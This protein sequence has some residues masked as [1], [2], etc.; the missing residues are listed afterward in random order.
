MSSHKSRIGDPDKGGSQD[1]DQL[2]LEAFTAA[3]DDS[4]R[5]AVRHVPAASALDPDLWARIYAEARP[6]RQRGRSH[7]RAARSRLRASGLVRAVS[8]SER[9]PGASSIP[10][11]QWRRGITAFTLVALIGCVVFFLPDE[12]R[13]PQFGAV[14]RDAPV[15]TT[16]AVVEVV[17]CPVEPLTSDEVLSIVVNMEQWSG[18]SGSYS[19][20]ASPP[21]YDG[22]YPHTETWLPDSNGYVRVTDSN[23]HDTQVRQPNMMEFRDLE[24][25]VNLYMNCQEEGTNFQIWALESQV[26]VQRQILDPLLQKIVPEGTTK[27]AYLPEITETM[28]IDEIERLGPLPRSEST[29]AQGSTYMSFGYLGYEIE[30]NPRIHNAYI[31]DE[32]DG[33]RPEYAWVGTQMVDV[34]SDT[35]VS[36][37]GGALEPS[38]EDFNSEEHFTTPGVMILRNDADR[39]AWLVEWMV[40]QI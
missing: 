2:E 4:V 7:P 10:S 40:P 11:S 14:V 37:R 19:L 22:A 8:S 18:N 6:R 1:V 13:E 39:G 20:F 5:D 26:E 29:V 21:P 17:G 38:E 34:E 31:S 3:L 36:I 27:T 23:L 15:I 28:I 30:A 9:P 35:V 32:R 25:T 33:G 24:A 12:P 16:P